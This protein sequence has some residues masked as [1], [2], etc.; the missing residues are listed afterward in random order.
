MLG[1]VVRRILWMIPLLVV[2]S[3]VSFVLVHVMPGDY[4]TRLQMDPQ[5]TTE[6]LDQMRARFG[7]DRPVLVQYGYWLRNILIRADFGM[8]F[9]TYLPVFETL[10]MGNRLIWTLILSFSSMVWMWLFAVVLGVYSATH[11]YGMGDRALT[12]FGFVVLSIPSFLF[13]L[14]LL[15]A[16]VGLLRVG[17]H[18]L[19]VGGLFD[20]RFIGQPWSWGRFVN[21]LW[22]VW[23]AWLVIGTS[24]MAGLMRYVRGSLLDVLSQPYVRAARAKGLSERNVIYKHALRNALN[25]LVSILGMSLPRLVTGSL[26]ASIVFN[27]PTVEHAFWTAITRQDQYVVVGGLLFF[28]TFLMAGNLLADVLLA[29]LDP[30]IRYD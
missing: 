22:H 11:Q 18:G 7:L 1:Y 25:P 13:A 5:I 26:V 28:G 15:W 27:L 6:T 21:L 10:F 2:V 19:G 30:R 23:P 20:S 4:V 29:C 17:E 16:L 8:S 12:T 14:V 9:E 3:F 24:G